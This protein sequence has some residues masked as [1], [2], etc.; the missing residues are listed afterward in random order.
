[1]GNKLDE[2]FGAWNDTSV[3][4]SRK[5]PICLLLDR[6]GSMSER[7]GTRDAKI[8]ELNRN[9]ASFITYVRND[10]RAS[11]ICDLCII[12]FASEV[13]VDCGYSSIQDVR[14]P[15][16][17]AEGG[18]A[19]GHA[20]DKAVELLEIRRRYY[21]DNNIEH[22]KPIMLIMTDGQPTESEDFYRAAAQRFSDRVRNK[23]FKVFPVGIGRSFKINILRLF[24][25]MLEPKQIGSSEE[26]SQLF[27]LL[28]GSSSRPEDDPLEKWWNEGI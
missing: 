22:F 2:L 16:L 11:K 25:P 12:S 20:V 18:T 24:S 7:D 9:V 5:V 6:S 15:Y 10:P 27:E 28:S 17:K 13:R 4:I 1:M 23:E 21:R 14:M 8:E 26:F 19:L 3:T